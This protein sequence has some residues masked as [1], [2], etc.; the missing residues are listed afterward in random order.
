MW[1]LEYVNVACIKLIFLRKTH[2]AHKYMKVSKISRIT[3][4][5]YKQNNFIYNVQLIF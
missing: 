2:L 4:E 5:D 1:K 3:E